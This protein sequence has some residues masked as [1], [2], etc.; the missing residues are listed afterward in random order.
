M[1][2]KREDSPAPQRTCD[3]HCHRREMVQRRDEVITMIRLNTH[4]YLHQ[5]HRPEPGRP[6]RIGAGRKPL[7]LELRGLRA[8]GSLR[9]LAILLPVDLRATVPLG[10]LDGYDSGQGAWP[11]G[12]TVAP[13][14]PIPGPWT[15]DGRLGAR[16]LPRN[17]LKEIWL[18]GRIAF[19][20]GT[21][22]CPL[23]LRQGIGPG[24]REGRDG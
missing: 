21:E 4:G 18:S 6:A 10:H 5:V 23:S 19:P 24:A 2:R 9:A 11:H 14:A 13:W 16:P 17:P 1:I 20:S 3:F 12:A 7:L 8:A 22:S 15:K